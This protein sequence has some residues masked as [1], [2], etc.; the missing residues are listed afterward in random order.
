MEK[1]G[2]VGPSS[3]DVALRHDHPALRVAGDKVVV[4]QELLHTRPCGRI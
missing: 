1:Q 3:L 4:V 2:I